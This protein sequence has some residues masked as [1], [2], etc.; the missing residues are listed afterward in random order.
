MRIPMA[1]VPIALSALLFSCDQR[2]ALDIDPKI[3]RDCFE[4]HRTSLPPGTQYEGIKKVAENRVTI[5]VMKAA[6]VTTIECDLKPA[7]SP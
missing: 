6:E 1:I 4:R 5:K 3:G 7:G 2:S